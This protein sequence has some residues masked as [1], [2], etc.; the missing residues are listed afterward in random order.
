MAGI[1]FNV[2]DRERHSLNQDLPRMAFPLDG[3][4]CHVPGFP[5]QA[6]HFGMYRDYMKHWKEYHIKHYSVVKC[7][8]CTV[9]VFKSLHFLRRHFQF[10]HNVDHQCLP[11]VEALVTTLKKERVTYCDPGRVLPPKRPDT[12]VASVSEE[13]QIIT[14][15]ESISPR[16]GARRERQR[17]ALSVRNILTDDDR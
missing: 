13:V 14:I 7:P 17:V 8:L 5:V 1:Q 9:R 16:E 10:D 11:V 4:F 2:S 3:M 6:H 12:N 15:E